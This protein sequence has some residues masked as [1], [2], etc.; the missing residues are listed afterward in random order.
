MVGLGVAV[1]GQRDG[2]HRGV[3]QVPGRGQRGAEQADGAEPSGVPAPVEGEQHD[4]PLLAARSASWPSVNGS[5]TGTNVRPAY[6]SRT[7]P[8]VR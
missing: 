8:G 4:R 3:G 5:V 6:C 1:R 2:D 7:W